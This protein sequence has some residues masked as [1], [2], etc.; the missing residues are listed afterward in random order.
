M[1]GPFRIFPMDIDNEPQAVPA[2]AP[3]AV[4]APIPV[5]INEPLNNPLP[6]LPPL[7]AGLGP[8][9]PHIVI[10]PLDFAN[11]FPLLGEDVE[12]E[13]PNNRPGFHYL[14]D[15]NGIDVVYRFH[16]DFQDAVRLHGYNNLDAFFNDIDINQETTIQTEDGTVFRIQYE[17]VHRSDN[18]GYHVSCPDFHGHGYYFRMY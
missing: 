2:P 8:N 16:N 11:L 6:P 1:T 12:D 9:V 17:V 5:E 15:N 13:A 4:P 7:P 14:N 10:P 3:A 18:D